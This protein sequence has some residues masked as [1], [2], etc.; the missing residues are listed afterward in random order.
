[1]WNNRW[2]RNV[3]IILF[4]NK[5]DK[6]KKKIEE[7]KKLQD[8]FPDFNTYT[9]PDNQGLILI[10]HSLIGSCILFLTYHVISCKSFLLYIANLHCVIVLSLSSVVRCAAR[11]PGDSLLF[12]KAKFFIRDQ[13]VVSVKEAIYPYCRV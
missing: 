7:G 2:L 11:E 5:Q 1:M 4:L 12:T 13:F 9:P 10:P 6:L 8:Y 3:S